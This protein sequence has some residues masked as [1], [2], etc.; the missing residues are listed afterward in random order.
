MKTENLNS[1]KVAIVIRNFSSTAGG[2]EKYCYEL[3]NKIKDKYDVT[4]ISQSVSNKIND[5]VF[6]TIGKIC[7]PRFIN[8]LFFAF[9]VRKISIKEKFDIVHSHDII[10]F[11]DIYTVHVPCFKTH[12]KKASGFKKFLQYFGLLISPRK[13]I[14]L[15]LE[16]IVF[17]KSSS[18]K[19][20]SVSELLS[21]NITYNFPDSQDP[22]VVYP[23]IHEAKKNQAKKNQ[24]KKNYFR[25]KFKINNDDFVIIFVGNGFLRKGL[26]QIIRA[27]EYL[28]DKKIFCFV[29]GKGNPNEVLSEKNKL[30]KKIFFLGEVKNM[31]DFYSAANVLIHPTLG[32]TFGMAVLEAMS[33]KIPVIVSD[34]NLCGI[35]EILSSREAIIL[36]DSS[37]YIEIA[38]NIKKLKQNWRLSADLSR[39]GYQFSKYLSWDLT[40]EKTI[41]IYNEFFSIS[42]N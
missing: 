18:K 21:K 9:Q 15:F 26:P 38:D 5:V 11:A 14:Y 27:M 16:G 20:I 22:I 25:E 39:N 36:K 13:L 2:A 42:K 35:S 1:P 41:T 12:L 8:H 6:L 19:I 10:P 30:N 33:K 40:A 23:G 17:N 7:K 29:A 32:D 24:A 28:N 34:K 31:E 4:V 3:T 37:N